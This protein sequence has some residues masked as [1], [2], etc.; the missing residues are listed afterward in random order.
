MWNAFVWSFFTC[1]SSLDILQVKPLIW[2]EAQIEKHS[3]SRIE[4][5]VK[6][7]SQ[8]KER[9]WVLFYNS[10]ICMSYRCGLFQRMGFLFVHLQHSNKCWN[11]SA[12]SFRRHK[13]KYKNFNGFCC[14]CP[15]ERCNGLE[16]KIIS[17]WQGNYYLKFV[18]CFCS[19]LLRG[20]LMYWSYYSRNTC[21]ERNLVFLA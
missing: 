3:R 10:K 1:L 21:A 4:L 14:I 17:W 9:R 8:F 6:A 20:V 19:L 18:L 5:M 12:C 13:P 11:W 7:R 2:V 16:S 15:W